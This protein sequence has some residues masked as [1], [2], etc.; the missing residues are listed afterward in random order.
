MID[1]SKAKD[2]T[3]EEYHGDTT[4]ISKSG[5]SLILKSPLHY[6]NR[7][8]NPWREEQ[9]ITPALFNGTAI[10]AALFEPEVFA[11]TYIFFDDTEKCKEIGGKSPRATTKYKDWY[12]EFIA[13]IPDKKILDM[14][15]KTMIT[16]IVTAVKSRP[17]EAGLLA[18]GWCEK[19]LM[20]VEPETGAPVKVRP[21]WIAANG[22]IVDFK[23]TEDAS[24]EEFGKSCANYD[25]DIQAALYTDG[26]TQ[27]FGKA[28]EGF[29]FIAGEKSAPNGVGIY[30]ATN[31]MIELGRR[32]YKDACRTYME[33][34]KTMSWPGY[35]EEIMPVKFPG[36]AFNAYNNK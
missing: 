7:Y 28:P 17:I 32:K 16:K 14:D 23:S 18:E 24:P 21:D 35:P 19:T 30:F 25:Y 3:N 4:H 10:H 2:M 27:V 15:Q 31:E 22:F 9:T 33:C 13:N 29:I 11:K 12:A 36:W 8:L 1:I 26:Y 5:L 6:W 20:F 34:K